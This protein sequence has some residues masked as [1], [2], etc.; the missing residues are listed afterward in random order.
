M[1][2]QIQSEGEV[3]QVPLPAEARARS[4]LA[5]VDYEDCFLMEVPQPDERTAEQWARAVLEDAP[6]P[7]QRS[8]RSAWR[9]LGMRIGPVRGDGF[10]LG[11]TV[12]QSEPDVV[13]LGGTS[14]L[15]MQ[16]E[17]VLERQQDGLLFATLVQFDNPGARTLWSAAVE[18]A[19]VRAVRYVLEKARARWH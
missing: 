19:H 10:V 14:R 2:R 4:S 8:L 12:R 18:R 7:L 6:A 15:G 1:A 13:L 5:H 11:W 17:L 16:A 9:S 3:R